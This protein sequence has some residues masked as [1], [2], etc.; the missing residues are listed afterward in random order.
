MKRC[1]NMGR[2]KGM[3]GPGR[4]TRCGT[5]AR[6]HG[7]SAWACSSHLNSWYERVRFHLGI[8]PITANAVVYPWMHQSFLTR[9]Y[10]TESHH[11][12]RGAV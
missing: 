4:S 8:A 9:S 12:I 10:L 11:S 5:G 7:L 3:G 1:N 6:L 2:A